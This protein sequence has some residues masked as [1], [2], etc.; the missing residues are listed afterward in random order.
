MRVG[1]VPAEGGP[2]GPGAAQTGGPTG[3]GTAR[4]RGRRGS[5]ATPA[6]ARTA[7][8]AA[9]TARLAATAGPGSGAAIR[10][11]RNGEPAKRRRTPKAPRH[12]P[13]RVSQTQPQTY[14]ALVKTP[15]PPCEERASPGG[16][17]RLVPGAASSSNGA[18]V[19]RQGTA[20]PVQPNA[21]S[22]KAGG[23]G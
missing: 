6:A 21:L 18:A 4:T 16:S 19:C 11:R 1:K 3:C 23:R 17:E 13:R 14:P 2:R 8:P 22:D 9:P 5:A 12:P 10:F 7:P 15:P 20:R